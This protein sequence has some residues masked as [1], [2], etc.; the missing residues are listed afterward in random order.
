MTAPTTTPAA[1]P[2]PATPTTPTPTGSATP[3]PAPGPV[4]TP[5]G[6]GY[7][8]RLTV[9]AQDLAAYRAAARTRLG[10]PARDGAAPAHP[11]V[12]AHALAQHTVTALTAGDPGFT[13]VV[14]L[15]QEIH[16]HTPLT[17]GDIDVHVRVT[18]ARREARGTRLALAT[19][20]TDAAT[21][22]PLAD[23][24]TA[25]LL[26]GATGTDPHGT[27]PAPA[28]P[29]TTPDGPPLTLTRTLSAA[30]TA[31]YAHASGDLNPLHLDDTAARAAGFPGTIAHGMH[32]V[33]LAAEEITDR[34]GHGDPARLTAL[35][36][37][38]AA[39][40]RPDTELR[41]T[42]Q[43]YDRGTVVRFTIATDAGTAVKA[44]WA[45]LAP[46]GE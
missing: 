31:A 25:A 37:R 6:P 15:A 32:L 44:G 41:L 29:G 14:H 43:P 38:F 8:A 36:A 35:G 7:R 42:L 10:P 9:T 12:A 19:R 3:A 23:L 27:L 1:T 2:A 28:H 20:L 13:G 40:A 34:H 46:A 16:T 21:G 22:T 5:A 17:A 33:A 4:A 39:P 24:A 26:L 30:D 18:A 45:R 11:F